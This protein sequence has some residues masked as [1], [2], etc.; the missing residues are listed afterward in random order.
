LWRSQ[1]SKKHRSV[2]I[3]CKINFK[4]RKKYKLHGNEL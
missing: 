3:A 4:I 2:G 1:I